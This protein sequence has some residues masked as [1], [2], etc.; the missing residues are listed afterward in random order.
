[1]RELEGQDPCGAVSAMTR[2]GWASAL[3]LVVSLALLGA[4]GFADAASGAASSV[5]PTVLAVGDALP[6]LALRDQHEAD[7][8]IDPAIRVLLYTRDMGGGG[9]VKA[10]LAEGGKDAL[11][12]AGAV[13]VSDVSGM[14]R[15]V[16]RAFALPSL[17]QRPYPVALDL[18]GE[19]TRS[20]PFAEGK[21]TVL[22][23]DAG[24]VVAIVFAS[25]SAEVTAALKP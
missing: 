9:L 20:L 6:A 14:P 12:V 15:L 2:G 11:A 3:M 22:S 23:L 16:L 24:K 5:A 19:V 25:T 21:V 7:V 10:A 13:Y 8:R 18:S 4:W 1:M 17:R